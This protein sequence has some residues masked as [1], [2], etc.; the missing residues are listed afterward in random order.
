MV[1]LKV[2]ET[3][4][5]SLHLIKFCRVFFYTLLLVPPHFYRMSCFVHSVL[6]LFALN[7]ALSGFKCLEDILSV[8]CWASGVPMVSS[9]ACTLSVYAISLCWFSLLAMGVIQCLGN[10]SFCTLDTCAFVLILLQ[11]P[12]A[13]HT[14]F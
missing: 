6:A 14:V 9:C 5:Y 8:L 12:S 2:E 1:S 7:T 11:T 4:L 10:V 13:M 3:L